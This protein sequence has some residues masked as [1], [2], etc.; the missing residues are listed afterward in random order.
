M[1]PMENKNI[2]KERNKILEQKTVFK[3][4]FPGKAGR[5]CLEFT[6]LNVTTCSRKKSTER[7]P[8]QTAG[9]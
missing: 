5:K 6:D 9:L 7:G 8:G 4:N 1:I 2:Y 3:E